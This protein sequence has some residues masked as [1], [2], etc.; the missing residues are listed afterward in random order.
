[1]KKFLVILAVAGLVSGLVAAPNRAQAI[2]QLL[3]SRSSGSPKGYADAA[4]VV[5]EDAAQG[6]PLQQF[7]L[8][9]VSQEPGAPAAERLQP[10]KKKAYLAASREKIRNLAEKRGNALAWYL[11][12]L[13]NNDEHMLQR[14]ADGDNVQALNAWGSLNVVRAFRAAET[15]APEE[16]ER[17][18]KSSFD[19][20]QRAANQD[21]PNGLYNLGTCYA[22]GIG[23]EPDALKAFTCFKRAAKAGHPEA[24]NNMGACYREG[25]SVAKDLNAA[26]R[27][28]KESAAL[29]NAFGELN[30]AFALSRG[31]GTPQDDVQAADYFRRAAEQGNAAALN[32][33]A[34]CYF[35]GK[36]V[37]KNEARAFD[38]LTQAARK[39]L[40]QAMDNLAIFY[41]RG[42]GGV[43]K[44]EK[45]ALVWKV[46]GKAARG[47]REA[48]AWLNKNGY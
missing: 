32:A 38:L 9:L 27:Y 16:K 48:Q 23:C 11:L 24:L 31:E 40:P 18:L 7:V 21:D 28:F 10:K 17:I 5:A 45:M 29:G 4:V 20:F 39:G 41:D 30:Y 13:E 12:S 6:R 43:A 25:I 36:G 47:S 22:R 8:A 33:Y 3:N 1:M 42:L 2:M 19:C 44:D 37:P 26:T 14:A 46:R 15:M 34:M 35:N